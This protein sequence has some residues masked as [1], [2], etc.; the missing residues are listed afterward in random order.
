MRLAVS[1]GSGSGADQA[2]V[3]NLLADLHADLGRYAAA[4]RLI[5]RRSRSAP[6]T[7]PR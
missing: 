1:A 2:S 5:A 4:E 7:R 3:Q 6:A